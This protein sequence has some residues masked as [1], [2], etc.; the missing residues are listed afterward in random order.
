[1]PVLTNITY[2]AD[3]DSGWST[4]QATP[5]L[6]YSS[7]DLI[8]SKPH[9]EQMVAFFTDD[10][11]HAYP[12]T[13]STNEVTRDLSINEIQLSIGD[14]HDGLYKPTEDDII[15]Y[16]STLV[17][18]NYVTFVD[19]ARLTAATLNLATEQIMH[20]LQEVNNRLDTTVYWEWLPEFECTLV[21]DIQCDVT[22][23]NLDIDQLFYD[24]GVLYADVGNVFEF[25]PVSTVYH[26][27][28]G[29]ITGLVSDLGDHNRVQYQF[30][31]NLRA[32]INWLLCQSPAYDGDSVDDVTV[33][34]PVN[35]EGDAW[36][37]GCYYVKITFE[38]ESG[39][40]HEII[41]EHA[42]HIV[43][44]IAEDH[45]SNFS[46][47][48]KYCNND[49][50]D[51]IWIPKLAGPEGQRGEQGV[52]GDHGKGFWIWAQGSLSELAAMTQP[53]LNTI[54]PNQ[55]QSICY[56]ITHDEYPITNPYK[57]DAG[58]MF[59]NLS[60]TFL[61]NGDLYTGQ[62]DYT[63]YLLRL[64]RTDAGEYEWF[65][66]GCQHPLGLG[67]SPAPLRWQ[68]DLTAHGPLSFP[69]AGKFKH[70]LGGDESFADVTEF[71]LNDIDASNSDIGDLLWSLL[72]PFNRPQNRGVMIMHS[73]RNP[74]FSASYV[75][76]GA[77]QISG[78][79]SNCVDIQVTNLHV[80]PVAFPFFNPGNQP[81]TPDRVYIDIHRAGD[82]YL[83]SLDDL[84]DVIV[85]TPLEA[86][87]LQYQ[88]SSGKWINQELTDPYEELEFNFEI[89]ELD[90]HGARG[91]MMR[92][93]ADL[94]HDY[95]TSIIKIPDHWTHFAIKYFE[96]NFDSAFI[97][98]SNNIGDR[99][100][101]VQI[102]YAN[103]EMTKVQ[104][105]MWLSDLDVRS[106]GWTADLDAD[107]GWDIPKSEV[108]YQLHPKEIDSDG[109]D[110]VQVTVTGTMESNL[111]MLNFPDNGS[112]TN[113]ADDVADPYDLSPSPIQGESDLNGSIFIRIPFL[114]E[115]SDGSLPTNWDHF[116]KSARVNLVLYGDTLT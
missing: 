37:S 21:A 50:T 46:I 33:V 105:F 83:D 100:P 102:W 64:E 104:E 30:I 68:Y 92:T 29:E 15:V 45:G 94:F 114:N 25:N 6:A 10:Q 11:R 113:P 28:T 4:G 101:I 42:P 86:E 56:F 14:F 77:S 57:G 59:K 63:S 88:Q 82:N 34:S 65:S 73:E 60:P 91:D 72:Q 52:E 5:P 7:F 87:V 2:P 108:V 31:D 35:S 49:Y 109:N 27:T 85:D 97:R 70:N 20:L 98:D 32:D 107:N 17:D 26:E 18:N 76:T 36:V 99:F 8:D 16:R 110:E 103:S 39:K 53:N 116:P 115:Q 106:D 81:E 38:M 55:R 61:D 19:G 48:L 62:G 67:A 43:D 47:K 89:F 40:T 80:N 22:Q 66:T 12:L 1:M 71:R 41:F 111:T 3:P 96:I 74:S 78:G 13:Y 79:G 54:P 95:N 69:L 84:Q 23:H 90:N 75:I 58:H 9:D 44:V 24:V 93:P 112:I 51:S